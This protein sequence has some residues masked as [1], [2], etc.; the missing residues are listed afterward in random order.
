MS[1]A[2]YLML[3]VVWL[4]VLGGGLLWLFIDELLYDMKK[5]R[6]FFACAT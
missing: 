3:T 4:Y 6:V 2:H 5:W 1:L